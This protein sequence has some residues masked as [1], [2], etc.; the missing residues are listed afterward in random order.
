MKVD[1]IRL[2]VTEFKQCL[3]LQKKLVHCKLYHTPEP[4]DM[5]LFTEHHPVFTGG[6]R[7]KEQLQF[8]Q[9]P[10]VNVSTC[11]KFTATE[12]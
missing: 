7:I 5:V 6:R 2:G 8:S 12:D 9:F 1:F 4:P 10:F 3:E 11:P